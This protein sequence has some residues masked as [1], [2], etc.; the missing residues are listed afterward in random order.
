MPRL[1]CPPKCMDGTLRNTR[2]LCLGIVEGKC[3]RNI[4]HL[5]SDGEREEYKGVG[6]ENVEV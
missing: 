5:R 4:V 6:F 1:I 2:F 3:S